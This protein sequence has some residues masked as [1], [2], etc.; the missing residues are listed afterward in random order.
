MASVPGLLEHTKA[1]GIDACGSK[2]SFYIIRS[3]LGCYMEVDGHLDEQKV[4]NLP[5]KFLY[6]WWSKNCSTSPRQF[7]Y[8]RKWS[9]LSCTGRWSTRAC[10]EDSNH[11]LI[12]VHLYTHRCSYWQLGKVQSLHQNCRNVDHYYCISQTFIPEIRQYTLSWSWLNEREIQFWCTYVAG[13]MARWKNHREKIT[14]R[15]QS[16][17]LHFIFE[18]EYAHCSV[19][20]IRSV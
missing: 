1:K 15:R 20:C 18:A 14:F 2:S 3:D 6:W 9:K 12:V 4:E 16:L 8:Q 5:F 11:Y 13:L 10:T 17:A 19:H 7:F